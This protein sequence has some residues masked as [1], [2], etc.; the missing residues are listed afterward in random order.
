M[1]WLTYLTSPVRRRVLV[2]LRWGDVDWET[3]E[4]VLRKRQ[5]KTKRERRVP[6]RDDVYDW[7]VAER[8]RAKHRKPRSPKGCTEEV[9]ARIMARFSK[10]HLFVNTAGTPLDN[11]LLRAFYACCRRA[12][13][14]CRDGS[15]SD[16]DHP[17]KHNAVDIHAL[18]GTFTTHALHGGADLKDVQ[19][20]LGHATPEQTLKAYARTSREGRRWAINCLPYRGVGTPRS[21]RT[22]THGR[23]KP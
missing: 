14:E 2:Q 7:L 19:H 8:E 23:E 6:I 17:G 16:P 9:C 5:T 18:R 4:V 20:M 13:I 1:V 21:H 15:Q 10:D 3:H 11:N 12:G 22:D